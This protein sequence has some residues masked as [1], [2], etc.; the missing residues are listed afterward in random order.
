MRR[1]SLP[2]RRE[3]MAGK[4]LE[5][6]QQQQVWIRNQPR[7]GDVGLRLANI[8]DLRADGKTIGQALVN[9]FAQG[10]G[11]DNYARGN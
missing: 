10:N 7:G 8:L 1:T 6:G 9:R 3:G 11:S 2:R 5:R 4:R